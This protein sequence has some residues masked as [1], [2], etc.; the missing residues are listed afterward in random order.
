MS[1]ITKVVATELG[2]SPAMMVKD[3]VQ[4]AALPIA[5]NILMINDI[6]MN[7]KCSLTLSKNPNIKQLAPDVRMPKLNVNFAP[8]LFI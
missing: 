1:I 7:V 8:N 6:V 4:K 3:A 2:N 5:S